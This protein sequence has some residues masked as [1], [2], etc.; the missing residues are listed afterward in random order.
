ME[1]RNM[2]NL[3]DTERKILEILINDASKGGS[4]IGNELKLSRQTMAS[5]ISSLKKKG[6]IKHFTIV[7]N[8]EKVGMELF[9]SW[10]L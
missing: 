2:E 1:R 9:Q 8:H 5:T 4:E 10:Y 7:L 6:V 3:S